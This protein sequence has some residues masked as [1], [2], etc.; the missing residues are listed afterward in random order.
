MKI[1]PKFLGNIYPQVS[2]LGGAAELSYRLQ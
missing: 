2:F 1:P